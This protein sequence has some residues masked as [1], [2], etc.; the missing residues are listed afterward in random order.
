[1]RTIKKIICL[2]TTLLLSVIGGMSYTIMLFYNWDMITA[3]IQ[4]IASLIANNIPNQ[5]FIK[6]ILAQL[7]TIGGCAMVTGIIG[8]VCIQIGNIINGNSKWYIPV[9]DKYITKNISKVL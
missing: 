9:M 3:H 7:I 5:I 1:M 8:K 2:V 6:L 4:S